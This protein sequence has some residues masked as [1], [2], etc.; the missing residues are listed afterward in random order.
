MNLKVVLNDYLDFLETKGITFPKNYSYK[1]NDEMFAK[2][3]LILEDVDYDFIL[4]VID[5][6]YDALKKDIEEASGKVCV[7]FANRVVVG[8]IKKINYI[9]PD[10]IGSIDLVD[11]KK[12]SL[13]IRFQLIYSVEEPKKAEDVKKAKSQPKKDP[14]KHVIRDKHKYDEFIEPDLMSTKQLQIVDRPEYLEDLKP[15]LRE[16]IFSKGALV[17]VICVCLGALAL[18]AIKTSIANTTVVNPNDVVCI[19]GY[20][21]INGECIKTSTLAPDNTTTSTT[22]TTT[23]STT[24]KATKSSASDSLIEVVRAI[25]RED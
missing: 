4:D 13:N 14:E 16:I 19:E 10:K 3:K 25:H 11:K 18:Y 24:T 7:K 15:S 22:Q 21:N 9:T 2:M 17:T 5:E 20:T 12:E 1:M 6:F 8:E 23:T